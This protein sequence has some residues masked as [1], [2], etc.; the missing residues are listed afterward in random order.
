MNLSDMMSKNPLL[1]ALGFLILLFLLV[2]LG[3]LIL[4]VFSGLF[5]PTYV[6]G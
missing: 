6:T 4:T 2:M 3:F 1:R 5:G